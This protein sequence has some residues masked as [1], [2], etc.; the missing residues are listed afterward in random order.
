MVD[1]PLG[2]CRQQE[3]RVT[4]DG[5]CLEGLEV[6]K[7]PHF[8]ITPVPGDLMP[9]TYDTSLH[10]IYSSEETNPSVEGYTETI[11]LPR[12]DDLTPE[13]ATNITSASLTRLIVLAGGVGSGKTTLLASMYEMFQ[14]GPFAGYL[15]AGSQTLP[16]LEQ[17]CHLARIAS[18]RI[19]PDTERTKPLFE[20]TLLHLKVRSE[21]LARPA[22]DLLITDLAGERF[23]LARDSTEECKKLVLLR[24]AD[25]F[26][27]LLD[28]EMLSQVDRRQEALIDGQSLLRSCIDAGMLDTYSMVDIVFTKWDLIEQMKQNEPDLDAFLKR[29]AATMRERF[30]IRLGRIRFFPVAARP[31]YGNLPFGHNLDQMFPSWVQDHPCRKFSRPNLID[32]TNLREFDRFLFNS[33]A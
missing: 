13:L 23:R 9:T 33:H 12:G 6:S 22:Q 20:D 32:R 2:S 5:K 19:R 4:V 10:P 29:I 28:G 11:D 7:C 14:K 8:S 3:C 24:R 1:I 18:Q 15:F 17:R 16:G 26:V 25:H 31:V 27:L 21:D 30:E